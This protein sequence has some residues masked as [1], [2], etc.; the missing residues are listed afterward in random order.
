MY[1]E[2]VNVRYVAV[3]ERSMPWFRSL[4]WSW[5]SV[6]MFFVCKFTLLCMDCIEFLTGADAD[7]ML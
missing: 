2:I 4:Q 7:L 1:R 5:F 3:K 6:A